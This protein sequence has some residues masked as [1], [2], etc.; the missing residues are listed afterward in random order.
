M[1][2]FDIEKELLIIYSGINTIAMHELELQS[3]EILKSMVLPVQYSNGDY[4]DA[5]VELHFVISN[6][7]KM[8]IY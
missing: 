8:A 2:N 1:I 7:T 4:E 5:N 6:E 3:L